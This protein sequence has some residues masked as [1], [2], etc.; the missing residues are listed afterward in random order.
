METASLAVLPVPPLWPE[1]ISPDR[2]CESRGN[3][4]FMFAPFVSSNEGTQQGNS[5]GANMF[6]GSRCC[7]KKTPLAPA[8]LS[9]PAE[10]SR[11]SKPARVCNGMG[12]PS[13]RVVRL[14]STQRSEPEAMSV[15]GPMLLKKSPQR[16]CGIKICNKRIRENGFLNQPC[17]FSLDP[18]SMLRAQIRKIVF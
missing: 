17:A 2:P 5:T 13:F 6:R 10:I 1:F 11:L 14:C 8:G 15:V 18:E 4:L 9:R 3:W 7:V 12:Q 16:N